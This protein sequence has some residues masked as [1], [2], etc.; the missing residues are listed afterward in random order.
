M[1]PSHYAFSWTAVPFFL[2]ALGIG[3][4]GGLILYWERGSRISRMFALYSA[5]FVLW[6]LGRGLMRLQTEPELMVLTMRQVYAVACISIPLLVQFVFVMLRTDA[7]R[8]R[9]VSLNWVIGVVL[10]MIAVGSPWIIGGVYHYPWGMEPAHGPLGPVVI[11][12]M[13]GLSLLLLIDARRAWTHSLPGTVERERLTLF[14]VAIASLV[15]TVLEFATFSGLPV[16]P[17]SFVSMLG[18]DLIT[19]YVTWRYGLVEVTEK[20]A[21]REIADLSRGALLLLDADGVIRATNERGR[22]IL[23][24]GDQDLIGRRAASVLGDALALE[25]LRNLAALEDSEAEK[26]LLY[27]GSDQGE[28]SYLALSVAAVRD[29]RGRAL[30]YACS[31]RQ[32][33]DQQA[34]P[35]EAGEDLQKDSLTGLP[36][37]SMFLVLLD[38]AAR[39]VGRGD[40]YRCAVLVIGLERLRRINEDLGFDAGDRVLAELAQR[41]R[42]VVRSG[43]ALARVG[44]D[45]FAVLM[46]G[47]GSPEELS[48]LARALCAALDLPVLLDDHRLILSARIG[49]TTGEQ[50]HAS[51]E[52]LLRNASIAMF[53]AREKSVPIHVLAS[54]DAVGQRLVLETEL[55]RALQR[56]ELRVYYQPVLDLSAGRV[57]G[58]EALVRWQHP[59]RGLLLPGSFIAVAEDI[60]LIDQIDLFVLRQAC[61]DLAQL[62]ARTGD[63]RYS[64]N[65]NL[66]EH[67]LRTPDLGAYVTSALRAANLPPSALRVELLEQ[68]AQIEPL[69]AALQQLRDL[70]IELHMDDFGSGYSALGRLHEVPISGIKLDRSLIQAMSLS[71]GGGKIIAAIVALAQ[72]LGLQVVAEGCSNLLEVQGVRRLG[73]TRAQG[74]YFSK[75]VALDELTPMLGA[76]G[77]MAERLLSM[78]PVDAD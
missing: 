72:S 48:S 3:V 14:S 32:M 47:Y 21:A 15:F 33:L 74:F 19:A 9:L 27:S 31:L 34:A 64:V 28:E 4:A 73:C 12:W 10:A 39:R 68:V 61:N 76:D 71:E 18:F 6:S 8:R 75:A 56:G 24:L 13:S 43:D 30:A 77:L 1:A 63:S 55:R 69:R 22:R 16:Y 58:F 54:G 25:S 20:L 70:D 45:E 50:G 44:S 7:L 36:G 60:G 29:R 5:L 23:K 59:Q 42:L 57:C 26:V 49:V 40:D 2:S 41:L 78:G 35:R 51:G 17:V 11:V 37:R 65:V 66:S 38:A 62:R 46:R 53:R 52:E 67:A